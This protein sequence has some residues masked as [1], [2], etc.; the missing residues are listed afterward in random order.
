MLSWGSSGVPRRFLCDRGREAGLP[1]RSSHAE[2]GLGRGWG[3]A[4][5]RCLDA[6]Q[7]VSGTKSR[8]ESRGCVTEF[9]C[10][11]TTGRS[12]RASLRQIWPGGK[13]SYVA[14]NARLSRQRAQSVST[15]MANACSHPEL[16]SYRIE[17]CFI[18]ASIQTALPEFLAKFLDELQ[19]FGRITCL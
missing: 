8:V 13:L 9:A 19:V 11:P 10:I 4:G 7:V 2:A 14:M 16:T 3:P 6:A 1:W 17:R 12:F 18:G 15:I 5:P